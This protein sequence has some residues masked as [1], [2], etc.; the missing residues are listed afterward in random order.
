MRENVVV[1]KISSAY[2]IYEWSPSVPMSSNLM[3]PSNA[4]ELCYAIKTFVIS[5][6]NDVFCLDQNRF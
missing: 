3:E 4:N 1:G 6:A 2:V 5:F